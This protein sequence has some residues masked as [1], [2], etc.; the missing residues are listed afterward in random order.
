MGTMGWMTMVVAVTVGGGLGPAPAG[1]GQATPEA[2]RLYGRVVT[3]AG[4]VYEGY[5]RWD[6]NEGSWSDVLDGDKDL[7]WENSRDARRLDGDLRR[8]TRERSVS[9]FGLRISWA[10]DDAGLAEA[11]RSGIR[12]GH[13]RS[14]AVMGDDRALLTLK[15]GEE[16]EL[17]GGGTDLGDELSQLVLINNILTG[18]G[19]AISATI[20]NRV[21]ME[22]NL[23]FENET[24]FGGDGT[25]V[26][27]GSIS[28]DPHFVN[29]GTGDYH[30][31]SD[32]PAP[33]MKKIPQLTPLR[34]SQSMISR[35][36]R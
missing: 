22:S 16:L 29:P 15:S 20:G 6:G 21:T 31:A 27:N 11:S 3:A 23:W 33:M 8:R 5:L 14:L 24:N 28:V 30:I 12:F 35:T 19:T 25:L 10:R 4:A 32:S 34:S 36:A 2:D 26:E 17:H 13:L 18:H 7:P 1:P 9:V